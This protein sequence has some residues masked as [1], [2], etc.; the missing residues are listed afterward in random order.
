MTSNCGRLTRRLFVAVRRSR[1]QMAREQTK[2]HSIEITDRRIRGSNEI[3]YLTASYR[4]TYSSAE[5]SIYRQAL[6]SHLWI[7]RKQTGVWVV[8]L[9]SWSVWAVPALE[10]LAI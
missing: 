5:D 6:G 4:T 9:V 3:A 10:P 1:P 8:T 2:I 7:L